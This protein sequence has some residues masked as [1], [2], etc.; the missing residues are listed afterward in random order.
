MKYKH[1]TNLKLFLLLLFFLALLTGIYVPVYSDEIVN[2]FYSAR[3]FLDNGEKITLFPQCTNTLG[4]MT[5][6]VFYP[7]A[8]TFS[9]IYADLEPLGIRISGIILGFSWVTLLAYWCRKEFALNWINQY[10][11]LLAFLSLGVIPYLW[12]LSRPEQFMIL[13]ILILTVLALHPVKNQKITSLLIYSTILIL[14]LSSFFY[15]HPK[16]LFYTPFI[17]LATWLASSN[18]PFPARIALISYVVALVTQ[19]YQDAGLFSNCDTAPMTKQLLVSGTLQ[20]SIFLQEPLTF[21]S[22]F[23]NNLIHFPERILNHTIFSSFFQS[24]WLPPLTYE[25]PFL[26]A[27]NNVIYF[28]LLIF[29]MA[30]YLL[31]PIY[32][33]FLLIRRKITPAILLSLLLVFGSILNAGFYNNQNFYDGLLYFASSIIILGIFIKDLHDKRILELRMLGVALKTLLF[34]ASTASLVSL[35]YMIAPNLI[36]S[37]KYERINLLEQPLSTPLFGVDKYISKIRSVGNQCGIP[38]SDSA[39]IVI[40]NLTYFAY[41]KNSTPLNLLYIGSGFFAPELKGKN[42]YDLL[43]KLNSPGIIASC[44]H[45]PS[46]FHQTMHKDGQFCCIKIN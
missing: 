12:V 16:S 17:L 36:N 1:I 40:D 23:I 8:I 19:T 15:V 29:I 46:Y 25:V 28:V 26:K 35:M 27:L 6:W 44:N 10:A 22:A 43:K 4:N 13:S 41:Y 20:P 9:S 31:V 39:Y 5:S 33:I 24:G 14:L 38:T 45:F 7:A 30:T 21:L 11:F 37:A 2:K 3:F 32:S 42:L 34:T 18:L